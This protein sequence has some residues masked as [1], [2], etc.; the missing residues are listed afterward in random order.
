MLIRV[1]VNTV[2]YEREV[3]ENR[4]LLRFLR[5][6]LGLTGTKEGCGA[7]E[8]GACTV[9]LNGKT[10]NSCMVLAVE[11]DGGVVQ[12]I[13]GEAQE[14]MLSAL[15]AA[16]EAHGAVQCGFCTAGMIMSARQLIHNNPHPTKEEIQEGLE[17]NFCRCTGY[18]QI[19]EAILDVT[20]QVQEKEELRYV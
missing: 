14:G 6:D 17:G 7:G 12:T 13:E 20:G 10:V 9:F 8:C 2:V 4:T 1:T 16:F 18:E 19:I 11:A 3:K 15:Q 5:E